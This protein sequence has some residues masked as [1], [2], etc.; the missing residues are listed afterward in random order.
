MRNADIAVVPL[1]AAAD[2]TDK[3][4]Y[5]VTM[6]AVTAKVVSSSGE[7]ALAI[8][9]IEDGGASGEQSSIA[10]LGSGL[11]RPVQLGSSSSNVAIGDDLTINTDGTFSK[12]AGSGSRT[13]AAVAT[14]AGV[15]DERIGA[16]LITR[17]A[18]S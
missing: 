17:Q 11:I 15:A 8:G 6:S 14:E 18:L 7:A 2:Q 16:I 4:G 13:R 5:A 9:V 1:T 10:L 12:D 3:A